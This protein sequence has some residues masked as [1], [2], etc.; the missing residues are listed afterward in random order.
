MPTRKPQCNSGCPDHG[1]YCQLDEGHNG[2]CLCHTDPG[3]LA[4]QRHRDI[5]HRVRSHLALR[6]LATAP[7]ED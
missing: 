3:N 6:D 4:R 2:R 1:S 7:D 5:S